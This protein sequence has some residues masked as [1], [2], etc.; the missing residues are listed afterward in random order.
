MSLESFRKL[1]AA[2]ARAIAAQKC[3][4][5]LT[6][7]ARQDIQQ[8]MYRMMRIDPAWLPTVSWECI[9]KTAADDIE[10]ETLR[11]TSW[12]DIYGDA[13]LYLPRRRNGRIP[14]MLFSPGHAIT[15]GKYHDTYQRMAQLLA[16]RGTAVLLFDQFGLGNRSHTGH[17]K[18][19]APF[20]CGTTVIGL[21]L[22]EGIAL[23]NKL[24]S[25]VRIDPAK[26]GIMGHS[27]GGQNTLFLSA[28]LGERAA[29]AV[30]SG[31]ACSFEYTARKERPLCA[32]DL[33]P[34][35]L[36]EF[37]MWHLLGCMAPK[38]L[39]CCSGFGDR[40]IARDV[41]VR[42]KHRLESF[43]PGKNCEVYLWNGGH[44]WDKPEEFNHVANF[45]LRNYGLEEYPADHPL[46]E[47]IFPAAADPDNP[48]YPA[49]AADLGELASRLTGN[50]LVY[51]SSILEIFPR[52]DFLTAGEFDALSDE[53]KELMVQASS[54]I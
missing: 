43:Y 26:V 25:D 34:G 53:L 50:K 47:T 38:P 27:G 7:A 17:Q 42:L 20:A 23:F 49:G 4:L 12:A 10:V 11:F 36:K 1:E 24:A 30:V 22:L 54:F 3:P 45:V 41:V 19:F 28:A 16:A 2:M 29:Q 46:P 48:P 5:P 18:M 40:M 39:L 14:A 32:C 21:M 31:F 8:R 6:S 37:E 33:F 44:A 35:V 52:P 13:L 51:P 9:R 15:D